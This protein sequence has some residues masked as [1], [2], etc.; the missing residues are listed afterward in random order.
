VAL[1]EFAHHE[2]HR[3]AQPREPLHVRRSEPPEALL[4]LFVLVEQ[5]D[6]LL[7]EADDGFAD[8]RV[9]Q[10]ALAAEVV[11]HR[12]LAHAR[13]L[14]DLR[15]RRAG[16]AVLREEPA[17]GA[18]DAAGPGCPGRGTA[19]DRGH[20]ESVSLTDRSVSLRVRGP[21]AGWRPG[22]RF[23]SVDVFRNG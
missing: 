13:G 15:H 1:G 4:G 6:Q 18:N 19:C 10:G 23:G 3:A 2:A 11:E 20:P 21:C 8:Q 22:A 9:V 7:A 16:V 17:G 14:G 12:G 5:R